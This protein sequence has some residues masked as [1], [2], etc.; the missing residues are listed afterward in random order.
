MSCLQKENFSLTNIKLIYITSD[1]NSVANPE[2]LK[3]DLNSLSISRIS[4]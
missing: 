2:N 1:A 3:I 4:E